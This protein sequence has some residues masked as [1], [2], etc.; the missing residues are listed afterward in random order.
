MSMT[1][2]GRSLREIATTKNGVNNGG[3]GHQSNVFKRN[4]EGTQEIISGDIDTMDYTPAK[5]NPPIHN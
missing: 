2:R 1:A 5:K 4:H 3:R